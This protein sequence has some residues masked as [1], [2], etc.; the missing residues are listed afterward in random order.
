MFYFI[1]DTSAVSGVLCDII[2]IE[3][4]LLDYFHITETTVSTSSSIYT[5]HFKESSRELL[6]TII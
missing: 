3:L 4:Y 2:T 5:Q 6:D 1:C